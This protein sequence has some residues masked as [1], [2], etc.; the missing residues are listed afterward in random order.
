L[1]SI[2][3]AVASLIVLVVTSLSLW[4]I[5]AGFGGA[6]A[7]RI[8]H[9]ISNVPFSTSRDA[10]D[11]AEEMRFRREHIGD[12]V[13]LGV[14]ASLLFPARRVLCPAQAFGQS[15]GRC[16]PAS[17]I[18]QLEESGSKPSYA[19]IESKRLQVLRFAERNADAPWTPSKVGQE[20]LGKVLAAATCG[21]YFRAGLTGDWRSDFRRWLRRMYDHPEEGCDDA[22]LFAAAACFGVRI[23]VYTSPAWMVM[24]R[25]T[26]STPPSAWSTRLPKPTADAHI[27]FVHGRDDEL[28]CVSLPV[29]T[30]APQL[31]P[32]LC[33][34]AL[35]FAATMPDAQLLG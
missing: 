23:F 32:A 2:A 17:V 13:Q 8:E 19:A 28:H 18:L 33:S 11:H 26:I 4:S 27:G 29:A 12:E 21:P 16:L 22:W 14:T 15:L 30:G 20:T 1:A 25:E 3:M 31:S 5:C 6:S 10:G 9:R 7:R 35:L 24:K 34:A